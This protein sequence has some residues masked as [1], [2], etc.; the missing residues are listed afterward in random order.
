MQQGADKTGSAA[1]NPSQKEDRTLVLGV[2]SSFFARRSNLDCEETTWV[3]QFYWPPPFFFGTHNRLL[4][5]VD[6]P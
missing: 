3:V 2:L 1:K 5:R 6:G 4:L